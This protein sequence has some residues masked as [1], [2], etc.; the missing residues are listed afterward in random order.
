[1]GV[2][3]FKMMGFVVFEDRGHIGVAVILRWCGTLRHVGV[4]ATLREYQGSYAH[5]CGCHIV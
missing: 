2:L 1:M 4:V 5:C 3:F